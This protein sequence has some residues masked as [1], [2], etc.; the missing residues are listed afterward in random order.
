MTAYIKHNVALDAQERCVVDGD[1]ARHRIVYQTTSDVL[2]GRVGAQVPVHWI[3]RQTTALAEPVKLDAVK[4]H[5]TLVDKDRVAAVRHL[6]ARVVRRLVDRQRRF[7]R[8]V[9]AHHHVGR[10]HEHFRAKVVVE[11]VSMARRLA[12]MFVVE[13]RRE[14]Q[15]A[16]VRRHL[17]DGA[18]FVLFAAEK[19][20]RHHH[21]FVAHAP[22]HRRRQAHTRVAGARRRIEQ[23]P[24]R[25]ASDRVRIPPA[26]V[27]HG[28]HFRA[29]RQRAKQL[30]VGVVA[31][32]HRHIVVDQQHCHV[33]S[34]RCTLRAQLKHTV[35]VNPIRLKR[36]RRTTVRLV[37]LVHY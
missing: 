35:N 3:A 16:A 10:E 27:E 37:C 9:A 34:Q 36:Y 11:A 28:Q 24:R 31:A 20:A 1:A 19:V 23:R 33:S 4:A 13:R 7:V 18:P 29:V 2:T 12:V 15:R 30:T 6:V 26:V 25:R 5:D 21:D 8:H 14:R 32:R 22:I 17:C